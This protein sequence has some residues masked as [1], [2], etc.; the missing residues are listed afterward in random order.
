VPPSCHPARNKSHNTDEAKEGEER[1]KAVD[2]E[3]KKLLEA[4]FTTKI[5]YHTWLANVVIVKKSSGKWRMCVDYT[6]LNAAWP[7][8]P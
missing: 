5:K 7:K 6:D 1:R 3:V 2:E 4:R 8:D